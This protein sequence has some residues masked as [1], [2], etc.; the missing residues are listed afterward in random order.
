MFDGNLVIHLYP[1]PKWTWVVGV[2]PKDS[3][4]ENL[5][6]ALIKEL[7]LIYVLVF[8]ADC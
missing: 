2:K 5:H 6:Q 1:Q 7:D 4:A 3:S 8:G